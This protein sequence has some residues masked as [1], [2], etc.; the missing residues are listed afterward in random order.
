MIRKN[1]KTRKYRGS[2]VHGFGRVGQHKKAGMRGGKGWAGKNKHLKSGLTKAER[3]TIGTYGFKRPSKLLK[4]DRSI[5]VSELDELIETLSEDTEGVEFSDQKTE[6]D[7]TQLGY[8]KV[9]GGGNISRMIIIKAASF[10]QKAID[11][12]EATG[13][14]AVFIAEE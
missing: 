7:A 14:K 10:S 1:K 4:R 3:A 5:N 12:I 13:G 11:K 6:I 9:L 8:S 2:R